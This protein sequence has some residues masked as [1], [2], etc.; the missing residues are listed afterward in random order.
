MA[1]VMENKIE[2]KEIGI[3]DLED[4]NGGYAMNE[5]EWFRMSRFMFTEEEVQIIKQK[6]NIS[7]TEFKEYTYKDLNNM[8][9]PGNSTKK[10]QQYLEGLG[11]YITVHY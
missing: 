9:I 7:L 3:N 2:N 10:V 5:G 11:V 6:T 4:V 8:G 1:D